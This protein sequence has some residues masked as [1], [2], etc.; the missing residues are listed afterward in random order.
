MSMR[1]IMMSPIIGLLITVFLFNI[2]LPVSCHAEG[3][4]QNGADG[5]VAATVH[6]GSGV[7]VSMGDSYSAGEGIQPFYGSRYAEGWEL[8]DWLAHR[9][10]SSWSGQ[11]TL[12]N[13]GSMSFS[14]YPESENPH[15][16]FGSRDFSIDN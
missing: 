11:L 13:V 2:L 16:Y 9:S 4:D 6:I 12:P 7:I 15:W 1:K 8:K 14:K 3:N 10:Q 5:R